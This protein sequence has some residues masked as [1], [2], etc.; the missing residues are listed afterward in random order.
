[1]CWKYEKN[2]NNNLYYIKKL[3]IYNSKINNNSF[4]CNK[5]EYNFQIIFP[6][7]ILKQD[8][9]NKEEIKYELN[10]EFKKFVKNIFDLKLW[11]D[12]WFIIKKSN[13]WLYWK[14]IN[15]IYEWLK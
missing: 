6:K 2:K 7:F 8:N 15:N 12:F 14:I 3:D 13:I 4:Y 9:Q 10:K 1:L 5:K 11:Y